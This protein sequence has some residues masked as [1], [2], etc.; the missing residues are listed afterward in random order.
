MLLLGCWLRW[1]VP[2]LLGGVPAAL[3]VAWTTPDVRVRPSSAL[4]SV[5]LLAGTIAGFTAHLELR[6]IQVAWDEVWDRRESRAADVLTR[7]LDRL[8]Q[9]GDDAVANLA[10]DPPSPDS[11]GVERLRRL[12]DRA[13]LAALAIYSAEGELRIWDGDHRGPVP[14]DVREGAVRYEFGERPLFSYLYFTAPIPET[15]G[16]AVAA[17]LLR[18]SLPPGVGGETAGFTSRVR[19]RTGEDV[20][21]SRAERIAGASA[22]DLRWEGR[23]LFSVALHEPRQSDER[24][25]VLTRWGRIGGMLVGTAW[26]LLALG[27]RGMS[28]RRGAAAATLVALAGVV[29]FGRLLGLASL[30][31][32][33]SF[34]LRAPLDATLLRTLAVAGAGAIV[35][36]LAAWHRRA[37]PR[38]LAA[39]VVA[40]VGFPLAVT[41]FRSAPA[42]EFVAGSEQAFAAFQAGLAAVLTL[43]AT[44]ALLAGARTG[45]GERRGGWIAG[46]LAGAGLLAAGGAAWV[47][48]RA[49]LPVGFAALWA[50]PVAGVAAGL[51]LPSGRL[52]AVHWLAAGALGATCALPFGWQDRVDARMEM[53]E[54][55]L[56]RL[57]SPVD[58]YSVFL[59]ERF[60]ARV[61]SLH[62]SGAGDVELLYGAWVESGLAEEGVPAWLTLWSAGDLPA[63]DLRIGVQPPRPAV[64]DAL[65]DEARER[66]DA[67]VRSLP[68]GE[69]RYGAAVPL[70]SG[71]AVTAVVP[72]R[73]AV[74]SRS[75]LEPLYRGAQGGDAGSLTIV[76]LLPGDV[77]EDPG[78]TRWIR[79]ASGWQAERTLELPEGRFHAHFTVPLADPMLLAARGTLLLVL[80][81]A[82]L[83]ALFG[84]GAAVARSGPLRLDALLGAVR[85]F[86]GRI[87]AALFGFF[88][89]SLTFF[90]VLGYQILS[91]AAVRTAGALAD[92]VADEAS[93]WY[94]DVQG[95]LD[96]LA[97]RV[98]GDL[99]EYRDGR[100]VGGSVTELVELGLYEGWLPYDVHRRLRSR[101]ALLGRSTASVGNWSYVVSYRRLPDG[102]VLAA[103]VPLE[104]GAAA[105]R[106]QEMTDLLRFAV[107]LGAGLSLG[108]AFLVGRALSRPIQDL[109]QAAGRVGRGDLSLRLPPRRTDEFGAVFRDFNRMVARLRRARADLLR[110]SQRT[111]AIVEEA[112]TGVIALDDSGGVTLVNPRA[113]ELLGTEIRPGEPL[114]RDEEAGGELAAWLETYFRDGVRA[115]GTELQRANRRVRVQARRIPGRER[116]LGGAVVSLEDVTDELRTERILAWGEMAQQVAHEVKNPLTPIKLSIQHILRAWRDGRSDFER[117]LERNAEAMLREIDRLAAI[118]RS[119]SRLAAPRA[120]GDEPLEA[121]PVTEVV[122]ETLDLYAADEGGVRFEAAVAPDLPAVR[123]RRDEMKEVLLNLLEN[124]RAAIPDEGTVRVEAERKEDG[125]ELRVQDDGQGIPDELLPRIFEPRFSTRSSGTGLGLAIVRRLAES[126]GGSVAAESREGEG[127]TIRI[128]MLRWRDEEDSA[129]DEPGDRSEV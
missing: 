119:F 71:E 41:M 122:E 125:V 59:L 7:E 121:V 19:A 12:R 101:E 25:A 81:L 85:T 80:D 18:V 77:V 105:L 24:E 99:L 63:E 28:G 108:L 33:A 14:A 82:V 46:G 72:P 50:L 79:T 103:P 76:P 112:A 96:L 1:P 123:G 38:P 115:A 120:A 69:A 16:T 34:L 66:E 8:L 40:G 39:A 3:L 124:A 52:R 62:R 6:R 75:R 109:R 70:P 48:L 42:P 57:A 118:A 10:D 29:P 54:R 83:G 102:D 114:P 43:V 93:G 13:D 21:L 107:L 100:L 26:L 4:A 31:S 36:G 110:T 127:T 84:L 5:I 9:A 129:L 65:R 56:E 113:E 86:R 87:T 126:W 15:G 91:G 11:V 97:R 104:A 53:A 27:C 58:P 22:W 23:T 44:V 30:D 60:A 55:E 89:L 51:A 68:G 98:G 37:P 49:G 88:L 74:A 32:P 106:R 116:R 47:S 78:T 95:S 67:V 45:P 35:A 17:A 20:R 94:L 73:T 117:I 90:G 128:S 111:R 2:W 61:D 92:R 64:T